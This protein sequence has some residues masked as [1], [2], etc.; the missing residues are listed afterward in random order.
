MN[1]P[2]G[3]HTSG[4]LVSIT[5]KLTCTRYRPAGAVVGMTN[6]IWIVPLPGSVMKPGVQVSSEVKSIQ[7]D[8][9][10]R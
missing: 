10:R 1:S 5:V 6:A 9:V 7:S 3:H 2:L 8:D 4:G